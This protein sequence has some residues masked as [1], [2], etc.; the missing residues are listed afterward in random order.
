MI[1]SIRAHTI[2]SVSRFQFGWRNIQDFRLGQE[3]TLTRKWKIETKPG[4]DFFLANAHD[5]L[6]PTRGSV[7]AQ[8]A[9]DTSTHVGEEF[10]IQ[11][12]YTPTRQTQVDF[13]FGH[14][15]TGPFLKQTTREKV[16][17]YPYMLIEYVF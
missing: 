13:G 1:R 15:F 16:A 3:F 5:A 2:S 14:V 4:H 7:I 10:D 8:S 12:I 9:K 6:Y 17:A 11:T